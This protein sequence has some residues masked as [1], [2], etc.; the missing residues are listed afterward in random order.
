MKNASVLIIALLAVVESFGQ[1]VIGLQLGSVGKQIKT[2]VPG[3]LKKLGEW[4]VKEL[5]AGVP[6]GTEAPEFLTLLKDNGITLI[7]TG[8]DFKELETDPQKVADRAKALGVKQVICYWIPHTGDVFTIDDA[9]KGVAVFNRAGE[10]L[11]K[12]G[13]ALGYH[14]HGYEFQ[15]YEGSPLFDYLAKNLDPPVCQ[16]SDGCFLDEAEWKR[17]CGFAE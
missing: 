5:E 8:S 13:L 17:S 4:G 7:A 9:K 3:T 16:F 14:A 15:S 11:K 2:D 1:P 10:V 6:T 12:N